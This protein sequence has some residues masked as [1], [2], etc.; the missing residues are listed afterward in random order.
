LAFAF[1]WPVP[2]LLLSRR[3]SG[4]RL[5]ILAQLAEPV[6]AAMS[7]LTIMWIK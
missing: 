7:T 5:T 1:L 4:S 2:V 6:L 3:R